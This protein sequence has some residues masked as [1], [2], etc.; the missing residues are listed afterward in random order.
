MKD[1]EKPSIAVAWNGLPAYAAHLLREA[2]DET[3]IRFTVIATR[4]DVP[5]QG[6]DEILGSDLCWVD[7]GETIVGARLGSISQGVFFTPVGDIDIL[8]L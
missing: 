2:R 6:M 5:I 4:P 7:R 8:F 1:L 3:G